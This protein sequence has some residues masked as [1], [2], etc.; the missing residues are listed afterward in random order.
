MKRARAVGVLIALVTTTSGAW[1]QKPKPKPK[2]APK[3]VVAPKPVDKPK[4]KPKFIEVTVLEIAGG[5]AYLQPGEQG[6][7]RRTA[8]IQLRGKDYKVVE[9]TD[10]YAVIKVE[11]DTVHEKDKGRSSIVEEE[12]GTKPPPAPPRPLSTWQGAWTPTISYSE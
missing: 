1:A 11:D 6:G 8:V 3:P 12:E 5:R 7:V 4:E 9:S 10:S 2:P